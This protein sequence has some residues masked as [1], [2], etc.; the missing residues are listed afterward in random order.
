MTRMMTRRKNLSTTMTRTNLG[1]LA[2]RACGERRARA[3]EYLKV[4]VKIQAVVRARI[5]TARWA[6]QWDE[7]GQIVQI[8]GMKGE[9][10]LTQL[11]EIVKGRFSDHSI[12]TY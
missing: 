11:L 9:P 3:D 6:W 2:S 1:F 4:E 8:S 7:A 5:P 10:R 12:K